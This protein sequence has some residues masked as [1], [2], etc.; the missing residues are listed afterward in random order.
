MD[1]EQAQK[2]AS[3]FAPSEYYDDHYKG[4]EQMYL[5]SLFD[6]VDDLPAARILEV[7]PG[8]GTTA[9]WLSDHGHDVTVM[10]LVPM[11]TF[12]PEA[13]AEQYDVTYVHHDIEDS[14]TPEKG[15][16]EPFDFVIMTQ[17]IHHL[18]WRP[19]RAVHHVAQ[20]M[21][22]DARLI[23]SV[24]D[25]KSYRHLD[26]AFGDD[27]RSVPQWHATPR[28]PDTIKCMYTK[29]SFESLLQTEFSSVRV[30]KPRRST[31]LFGEAT[32]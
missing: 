11:G 31:V 26:S 23:A 16:L 12:F 17:V 9:I 1:F 29:K 24:L 27:W 3:E 19:D 30:W 25:R 22:P 10:D 15:E 14:A 28:N 8:W 4:M 21:R 13:L 7:G 18:S 5:P 32:H 2:L 20:L 6:L